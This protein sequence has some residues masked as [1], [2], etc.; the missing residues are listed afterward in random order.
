MK[1]HKE[2]DPGQAREE[3]HDDED[4][5]RKALVGRGGRAGRRRR[6]ADAGDEGVDQATPLSA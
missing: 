2:V 3:V 5:S 1:K 6:K 4:R